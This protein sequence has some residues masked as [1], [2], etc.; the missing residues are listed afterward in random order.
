MHQVNSSLLLIL[1]LTATVQA[2]HVTDYDGA[3]E[4]ISETSYGTSEMIRGPQYLLRRRSA[5]ETAAPEANEGPESGSK[6]SYSAGPISDLKPNS[7]NNGGCDESKKHGPSPVLNGKDKG[8]KSAPE[9]E[10]TCHGPDC[11]HGH[12]KGHRGPKSPS[13]PLAPEDA[14]YEMVDHPDVYSSDAAPAKAHGNKGPKKE[15][16]G[17]VESYDEETNIQ[18]IENESSGTGMYETS[19]EHEVKPFHGGK[20]RPAGHSYPEE[21]EGYKSSHDSAPQKSKGHGPSHDTLPYENVEGAYDHETAPG[22]GSENN[23]P[24]HV[25]RGKKHGKPSG[26][27]TAPEEDVL[28]E[29]LGSEMAAPHKSKK[30]HHEGPE[31][32]SYESAPLEEESYTDVIPDVEAINGSP[33]HG[34]PEQDLSYGPS[35]GLHGRK[36]HSSPSHSDILPAEE[37]DSA[38]GSEMPAINHYPSE[39]SKPHHGKKHSHKSPSPTPEESYESMPE[40]GFEISRPSKPHHGN[41]NEEESDMPFPGE[42]YGESPEK[43][44]FVP[45]LPKK[46]HEGKHGADHELSTP[47]GDYGSLPEDTFRAPHSKKP[48]HGK[49]NDKPSGEHAPELD[50]CKDFDDCAGPQEY[51]EMRS[52]PDST[53]KPHHGKA[54]NHHGEAPEVDMDQGDVPEIPYPEEDFTTPHKKHGTPSKAHE[55]PIEDTSY[56]STAPMHAPSHGSPKGHGGKGSP[57]LGLNE[58]ISYGGSAPETRPDSGS[59]K[60]LS[61]KGPSGPSYGSELPEVE[62]MPE[63]YPEEDTLPAFTGKPH[64]GKHGN[65]SHGHGGE[66]D[67]SCEVGENCD[68]PII[69]EESYGSGPTKAKGDIKPHHESLKTSPDSGYAPEEDY[70]TAPKAFSAP[71][72]G[73]KGPGT[74]PSYDHGPSASHRKTSPENVTSSGPEKENSYGPGSSEAPSYGSAPSAEHPSTTSKPHRGKGPK[75]LPEEESLT[76]EGYPTGPSKPHGSSKPME[77]MD[78]AS[79]AKQNTY[80][81][82][83][84]PKKP[85]LPEDYRLPSSYNPETG[86]PTT[87]SG[88]NGADKDSY[89]ATENMGKPLKSITKPSKAPSSKMSPDHAPAREVTY[90]ESDLTPEEMEEEMGDLKPAK[91]IKAPKAQKNKAPETYGKEAPKAEKN[92]AVEHDNTKVDDHHREAPCTD[93]AKKTACDE[94]E[95]DVEG[96]AAYQGDESCDEDDFESADEWDEIDE[97]EDIQKSPKSAPSHEDVNLDAHTDD[98]LGANEGKD[99]DEVFTAPEDSD[100]EDCEDEDEDEE[101]NSDNDNGNVAGAD[102]EQDNDYDEIPLEEFYGE[103]VAEADYAKDAEIAAEDCDD[104]QGSVDA[105]NLMGDNEAVKAEETPCDTDDT[106]GATGP[107]EAPVAEAASSDA[108]APPTDA[109]EAATSVEDSAPEASPATDG[110]Y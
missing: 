101:I 3:A 52:I 33:L 57:P 79:P 42:S 108:P 9:H 20:K 7:D 10:A 40:E 15:R 2:G 98:V 25:P 19:P 34:Q 103:D 61:S 64:G 41:K 32:P 58:D 59:T 14:S 36:K 30:H 53:E 85:V 69:P 104:D 90:G 11:D 102:E 80:G 74:L 106:A 100:D 16:K 91:V 86:Y 65:K 105:A 1:A 94:D 93:E 96:K 63:A 50:S 47:E 39:S 77:E 55:L 75:A 97:V 67:M 6:P 95:E 107:T 12:G 13:T 70:S 44:S 76:G 18:V 56:G 81:S 35:K 27:E 87:G 88:P 48:H 29:D 110:A 21:S 73:G 51:E 54:K 38:Y 24:D 28:G 62:D 31:A 68:T 72:S 71:K 23:A 46:H 5:Y 92:K 49:K 8:G 89:P 78:H 45:S 66:E 99:E 37:L 83:S 17:R 84:A 26:Y 60:P 4:D 22:Y 43:L 82:P 109:V